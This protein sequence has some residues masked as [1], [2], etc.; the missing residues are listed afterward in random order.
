LGS[1]G[2]REAREDLLTLK[3]DS[4][5][6]GRYEEGKIEDVSVGQLAKE[7]LEKI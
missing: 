7:A 3:A 1:V 4:N 6:M 5:V 2:A